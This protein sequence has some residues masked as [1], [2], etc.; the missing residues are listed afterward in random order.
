MDEFT[1]YIQKLESTF[2]LAKMGMFCAE[3]LYSENKLRT[4][5]NKNKKTQQQ[6]QSWL[7]EV[8]NEFRIIKFHTISL[9]SFEVKRLEHK[10]RFIGYIINY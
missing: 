10:A 3:S 9:A 5:E 6:Q 4:I 1:K 7:L 8:W 2:H